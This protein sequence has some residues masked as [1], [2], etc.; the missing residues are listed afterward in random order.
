MTTPDP[1]SDAPSGFDRI[2][3]Y[4]GDAL[5]VTPRQYLTGLTTRHSKETGDTEA[6]D[7]DLVVLKADGSWKELPLIRV[8]PHGLVSQFRRTIGQMVIGHLGKVE[9]PRG[10]AWVMDKATDAERALGIRYL[11]AKEA[12]KLKAPAAV[13]QFVPGSPAPALVPAGAVPANEDP[14]A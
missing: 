6:V 12:A 14:F 2:Q 4:Y 10:E 5:I 1:F 9:T 8:Y 3:D 7:C 11:Q 13:G